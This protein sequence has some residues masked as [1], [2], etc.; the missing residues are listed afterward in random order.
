MWGCPTELIRMRFIE[1]LTG[2]A[3]THNTGIVTILN[4][5]CTGCI[6]ISSMCKTEIMAQ[7]VHNCG[8]LHIVAADPSSAVVQNGNSTS[9][10]ICAATERCRI[11]VDGAKTS[12]AA[13]RG[14]GRENDTAVSKIVYWNTVSGVCL[15][16]SIVVPPVVRSRATFVHSV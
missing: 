9:T 15:L 5:D 4:G 7:L 2:A 11:A 16:H 13:A 1:A 14:V 6:C 10:G 8:W 12:P 3:I